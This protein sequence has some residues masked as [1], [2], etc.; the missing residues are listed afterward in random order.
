MKHFVWAGLVGLIVAC[1]SRASETFSVQVFRN[2]TYFDGP[3]ADPVRH[4]LDI[5]VPKGAKNFPVL[6]FVHGGGWVKG[7]KDHLGVYT[8]L[9]Q[10]FARHGIGMVCPNY[11]LSPKF[12]HPDHIQDVAR[13]F[14]W[15]HKN[16]Q[17]YG[18]DRNSLFVGG[19][20]AGGHLSALLAT[21]AAYL[22]AE[23]LALDSI[24]G[25]I[26]VSG[27]F[28]IPDQQI[29]DP[30]FGKGREKHA[31]ASPITHANGAAPPFLILCGE[32]DL[33][34]C[35]RPYAEKFHSALCAKDCSAVFYEIPK[36]NHLTMLWNAASDTDAVTQLMLGF[37]MSR[38]T[39]DRLA[40]DGPAALDDFGDYLARYIGHVAEQR[41]E[42]KNLFDKLKLPLGKD[43]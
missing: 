14:A 23:G 38:R 32:N 17:R 6:F 27:V 1:T 13:A 12:K 21:D 24:C 42:K 8:R 40:E 16:I 9:A 30:I 36:R 22:K 19:H 3:D 4:K 20:S 18:G 43:K 5:H 2:V 11:R 26:P 28:I 25:A 37:I 31:L 41:D 39:L 33:P 35:D 34:T 15:T 10:T 29:F 7:H